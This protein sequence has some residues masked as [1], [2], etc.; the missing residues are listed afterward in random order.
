MERSRDEHGE[1]ERNRAGD[2]ANRERAHR[3]SRASI[4][5]AVSATIIVS[6]IAAN[7]V[8]SSVSAEQAAAERQHPRRRAAADLHEHQQRRQAKRVAGRMVRLIPEQSLQAVDGQ[9]VVEPARDRVDVQIGHRRQPDT[10]S[11][12]HDQPLEP[13]EAGE[14]ERA[15]RS[16]SRGGRALHPLSGKA[17][18]KQHERQARARPS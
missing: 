6:M 2:G 16:E 4:V 14:D 15:E 10:R 8:K 7:V 5:A 12:E 11:P 1:R 13:F 18:Q 3:L 17:E 9:A